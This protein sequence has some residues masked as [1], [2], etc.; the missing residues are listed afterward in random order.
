MVD[1]DGKDFWSGG[2]GENINLFMF[3]YCYNLGLMPPSGY[4]P[5]EALYMLAALPYV[6]GISGPSNA[7]YDISYLTYLARLEGSSMFDSYSGGGEG[8]GY[9]ESGGGAASSRLSNDTIADKIKKNNMSNL[10]EALVT[11]IAYKESEFS[12]NAKNPKSSAS[13]L[14]Q[15][16]KAAVKDVYPTLSDDAINKIFA[17]DGKIFD[18]DYNISTGTKYLD[19]LMKR[20]GGNVTKT[21]AKY[22][23][24]AE[25]AK[26]ILDCESKVKRGVNPFKH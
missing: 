8:S 22:G 7:L 4:S 5:M 19:I 20:N 24:G 1:P 12:P 9:G 3:F 14:M 18:A 2:L 21:L 16:T 25:Y 10:S 13:G 6:T 15:L 17:S 11:C 26:D 23:T